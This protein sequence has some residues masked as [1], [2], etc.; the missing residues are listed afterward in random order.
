[1][2]PR[3]RARQVKLLKEAAR[4]LRS[5]KLD[6]AAA[7]L[8]AAS[9]AAPRASYEAATRHGYL[10]LIEAL[11]GQ[12]SRAADLAAAEI[13]PHGDN[14]AGQFSTAA[15]VALAYVHLERNERRPGN[16]DG[17]PASF[18]AQVIPAG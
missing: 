12:L 11:R 17:E 10:A 2:R 9:A 14:L 1:M 8:G 16:R 7:I 5:G 4:V 15:A 6:A 18:A 13:F 3:V